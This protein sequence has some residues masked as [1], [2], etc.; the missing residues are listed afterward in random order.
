M[1]NRDIKVL[2]V[3]RQDMKVLEGYI[4][5]IDKLRYRLMVRRFELMD[6]PVEENPGSSR[7]NL[8]GD[9]VNREV[10]IY[11][12]DDYYNNLDKIIKAVESVYDH[13]DDDVKQIFEL[14]YWHPKPG[15]ETWE[16]LAKHLHYSKTS[17]LRVRAK[18]LKD[19]ANRMDYVNSDF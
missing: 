15:V 13:A 10:G 9:P 14:K 18:Y 16:E 4:K 3:N 6:K 11:L 1:V 17:L 8:P 5:N 2:D 19:I 7:S 12:A